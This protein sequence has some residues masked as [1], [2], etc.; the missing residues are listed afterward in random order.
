MI[1]CAYAGVGKSYL[2]HNFPNVIDLESTPFE[3]DWD[4]YFK[5]AKHYSDQEF[6]VLLSCHKEIRQRVL[7][8]PFDERITIF[9]CIRDKEL[10]RKRYEQRGN[11]QEFIDIQMA[12]WDEWT[13]DKNCLL[14]EHLEYMESGEFLYDTLLRLSKL[15]PNRFCTYDGCLVSDCSLM[16][17]RC[18]NP[19]VKYTKLFN[20][21]KKLELI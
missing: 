12:N 20:I 1:I 15:S 16:K 18:I 17:E 2:A 8:L 21:D 7:S 11:T 19:L 9:P 13:S 3:K 5:C 10:F 6:L 4:R 14:G